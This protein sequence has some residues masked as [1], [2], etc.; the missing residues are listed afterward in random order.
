MRIAF[1]V[2]V[3]LPGLLAGA[4]TQARAQPFGPG[5]VSPETARLHDIVMGAMDTGVDFPDVVATEALGRL[6]LEG[7]GVPQDTLLGCAFI[8]WA[9]AAA[10]GHAQRVPAS[11][12]DRITQARI[13]T[14]LG[15]SP[16]HREQV[17]RMM[18][19]PVFGTSSETYTVDGGHWVQ[20]DRNSIIVFSDGREHVHDGLS[21][22]GAHFVLGR[23]ARVEPPT[24]AP[25]LTP[26][27]LI[28]RFVWTP[29][30]RTGQR[31]LTWELW[32]I[33]DGSVQGL[34]RVELRREAGA[35][36][37][38]G[39]PAAALTDMTFR[40]RP[41]GGLAWSI[42]NTEFAGI[43]EP[44]PRPAADALPPPPTTGTAMVDVTVVDAFGGAVADARVTLNGVVTR[45]TR[46]SEVGF[47]A[48]E[49]LPDGRYDIAASADGLARSTRL[50]VDLAAG[51]YTP[52]I[53][54]LKPHGPG[55]RG[56]G[57]RSGIVDPMRSLEDYARGTDLVLHV[58]VEDQQG[59]EQEERVPP[60]YSRTP[61]TVIRTA[62]RARVIQAFKGDPGASVVVDQLGGSIDR[63]LHVDWYAVTPDDLLNVGD[64]YVL[65]L[66]RDSRGHL[67]IRGLLE[68]HFRIRNGRVEPAGGSPAAREWQ[69][70]P[71]GGFFRALRASLL[72]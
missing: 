68:G 6:Y 51:G 45:Q 42:R 14:C 21:M 67:V 61:R 72:R 55:P 40:M 15:L 4:S 10:V 1:L 22:C 37:A 26:R 38:A 41:D 20:I 23:Y 13:A 18:G 27:H 43:V 33:V 59:Y 32:E 35:T 12:A 50:V 7:R 25:A 53:I 54:R 31:L 34:A 9:H 49:N 17:V 48:F 11:V 63:G 64:E 56:G 58:Q 29:D 8:D 57:I 36:W 44:L 60:G 65:F 16:H 66:N 19:C 28:E 39:T 3:C 5:A 52:F 47:A 30:S 69:G 62:S 46:T 70:R 71:P 24:A 2:I